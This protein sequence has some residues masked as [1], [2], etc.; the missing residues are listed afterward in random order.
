MM[1][2]LGRLVPSLH[3]LCYA[4]GLQLVI[5]DLF[6]QEQTSSLQ[7]FCIYSSDNENEEASDE[8]DTDGLT[9]IGTGGKEHENILKLSIDINGLVNKVLKVVKLFK[10]SPLKNEILQGYVQEIHPNGLNLIIDCKTCWSSLLSMLERIIK[11]K[12]PVQ[13]ALLDLDLGININDDEFTHISNIVKALDP[14]KL[15]VEALCRRDANFITAEATIKFL[16]EEIQNYSPSVYKTRILEAIEERIIQ[17]RYTDASVI[18]AYLHNPSAKLE[19]KGVVNRFCYDILSRMSEN[20]DM[21][22]DINN[23]TCNS[24]SEI[25]SEIASTETLPVANKLQLAIDASMIQPQEIAQS[26][27]SLSSYLKYELTIAEQTGRRGHYLEKVYKM[28]LTVP[29][30]SVEA[31]R[32]FSSC[33]YLC[34]R[35]RTGLSDRTLDTLCSIRNNKLNIDNK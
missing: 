35:F 2:K 18:I 9:V 5:Q 20:E 7:E 19:K 10:R 26:K 21:E 13:K 27:Q 34:N 31:E 6:Y 32:I 25:I 1:K 17:Q 3:Q 24:S 15:A 22:E 23:T 28:L 30:T 12:Q 33:A 8:E 16:L 29:P 4:H 14:I 11:I